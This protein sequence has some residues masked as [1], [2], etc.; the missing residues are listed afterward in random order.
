MARSVVGEMEDELEKSGCA[1]TC[2]GDESL[3]GQWDRSRL[4]QVVTNLLSNAM[5]YGG[6]RPIVVNVVRA[7][8]MARLEVRDQGIGIPPEKR[9]EIFQP[10]ERAV[11]PN[12]YGGLG[13]GLF[14]VRRIVEQHQGRV[15]VESSPGSG[16]TFVVELPI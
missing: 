2:E 7:G 5:K 11:S 12:E 15:S 4:E 1:V 3:R 14:I 9:E 6:K 13:L 10:F 16:A 8:A